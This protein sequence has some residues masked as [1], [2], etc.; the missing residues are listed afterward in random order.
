RRT[1]IH[2]L[3]GEIAQPMGVPNEYVVEF[4]APMLANY[5]VFHNV[6]LS[7]DEAASLTGTA[8]RA[9]VNPIQTER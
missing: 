5:E 2:A 3:L 7:D 6:A 1:F 4:F 8:E 9:S